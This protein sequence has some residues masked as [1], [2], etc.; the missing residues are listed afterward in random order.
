MILLQPPHFWIVMIES[1][2]FKATREQCDQTATLAPFL[3]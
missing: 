1:S 3:H 2:Q